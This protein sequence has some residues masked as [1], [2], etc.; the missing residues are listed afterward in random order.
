MSKK[1]F[2]GI[3]FIFSIC[4]ISN[5]IYATKLEV[6]MSKDTQVEAGEN[7]EVKIK[8]SEIDIEEGI[9][10]IQGKLEYDKEVFEKIKIDD[11]S[12]DNNWSIAY[13]DEDTQSEGKFILM[14][15][16][17]S[18]KSDQDIASLKLTVKDDAYTKD[19]MIQMTELCTVKD[20]EIINIEDIEKEIE[21][22]GKF[23]IKNIFKTWFNQIKTW[24]NK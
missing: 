3:C 14:N 20:D 22:K 4:L 19:A 10:V 6:D 5:K 8:I 12:S 1:I 9:N 16:S 7:I 23:S 17:N 18:V 15:L 21:I 2:I 11:F 13:N 24:F